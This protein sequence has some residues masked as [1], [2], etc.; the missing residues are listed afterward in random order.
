VN[1]H[2][3]S[4]ENLYVEAW[5]HAFERSLQAYPPDGGVAADAPVRER[6]HG[7]ILAFLRRIGDPANCEVEIMHKEM[8]NP[9]GLLTEVLMQAVGPMRRDMRS[10]IEEMLGD[11]V[12]EPTA[13]FCEMSL[14][15]Q[16]F[17]P[18]L[19]LRRARK[20]SEVPRPPDLPFTLDVEQ[21]AD[22]VTEFTLA[23]I[24]GIRERAKRTGGRSRRKTSTLR[25]E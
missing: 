4:K 18:M 22:H 17:G 2:F 19:H 15:G 16:C 9:T 6:L 5:K 8:A 23:G 13:S 24:R 14:M 3:G 11:G 7:R 20:P 21:L 12:G 1:Y 10:L 25:R